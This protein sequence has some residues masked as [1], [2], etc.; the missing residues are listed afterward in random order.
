VALLTTLTGWGRAVPGHSEVVT[1]DPHDTTA[2]AAVVRRAGPRGLIMRGLGRS[3]GDPAQNSGGQVV[4]LGDT[5][6]TSAHHLGDA[7]VRVDPVTGTVTAGGGVSLAHLLEVIVPQ[8]WFVPVTPGTRFVTIGGAI[9]S[10]IHGKNHHDDAEYGGSFGHHVR[11]LRLM[12]ADTSIV[13]VG[14]DRD[15]DLFWATVGGMGLTGVIVSATFRVVPIETSLMS[16]ETWRIPSLD[17]LMEKMAES[18]TGYRYSV[19][20]LDLLA[21]GRAFGRGVLANGEHAVRDE[22][23]GKQAADPLRYT[24]RQIADLP[25]VVPPF[26][27]INRA[28]VKAFNEMWYRKAPRHRVGQLHTIA[29][30][31]HPLDAVGEWNRVY[32]RR[33][34]L[35]YQFVVPHGA[36]ETLRTIIGRLSDVQVASFMTVLK[37]FGP[38]NPGMLSFPMGG[39]TLAVDVATSHRGLAGL[40]REL[41]TLVFDVGGRHYLAKDAHMSADAVRRGYPRLSEFQTVRERVDPT[42]VW[43]SDQS[44]RLGL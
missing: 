25:P 43:A 5:D 19:A 38:G 18:D 7:D 33:G 41:D 44:R 24:A 12:L 4:R 1:V 13:E 28:T 6:P 20:W 3:Y 8:G 11:S 36:E 31:F 21:R 39:W 29:G 2:L 16:V 40:L 26:G 30:Y 32:G 27:L 9:A 42:R 14:P 15:P 34:F 37:R 10:D 23:S 35:Q 17:A 22:L